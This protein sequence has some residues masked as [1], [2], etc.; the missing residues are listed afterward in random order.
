M[1]SNLELLMPAEVAQMLGVAPST[2]QTWRKRRQG[3]PHVRLGHRTVRYRREALE[4][5]IAAHAA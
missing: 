5:W 2:L 3:P 4:E 1:T